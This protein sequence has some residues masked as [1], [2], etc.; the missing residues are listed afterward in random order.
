MG[1]ALFRV[2]VKGVGGTVSLY[3]GPFIGRRKGSRGQPFIVNIFCGSIGILHM[4]VSPRDQTVQSFGRTAFLPQIR[5][6]DAFGPFPGEY[7]TDGIFRT[8]VK[9]EHNFIG[10]FYQWQHDTGINPERID[11]IRFR[12]IISGFDLRRYVEI[13]L[14]AIEFGNRLKLNMIM[15]N[16]GWEI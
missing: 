16:I 9:T 1:S 8:V 3:P 12:R 13:H 7:K 15:L 10:V 14:N 11:I 5:T 4:L 6:S 2:N